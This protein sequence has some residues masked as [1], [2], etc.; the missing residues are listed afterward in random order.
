METQGSWLAR[1]QEHLGT[2]GLMVLLV[3]TSMLMPLSLDMYTPAVPHMAERLFTT[4]AMVNLT[5]VGYNFF[6]AVG[7]LI[8][9]P[10]SDRR[11]RRPVLLSGL[12]FYVA[13]SLACALAPSIEALIVARIV[14]SLGAG[15]ADA[16]TNAIVKDAFTEQRRQLAISF[17][18][19]MFIL[20][21]VVAPLVGAWVVMALD[22]R[23]TFWILTASGVFLSALACAF[24]ESLPVSERYVSSEKGE[25]VRQFAAVLKV[26]AFT[27][28]LLV[29]TLPNLGFMAYV[30]VASFVYESYFG[31]SE[32]GYG[33]YYAIAALVTV[34]G[35]FAWELASRH[36]QARTF[37]TAEIGVAVAAGAALLVFGHLA[38]WLFC[39]AFAVFAIVEASLRP[40]STNILLSKFRDAGGTTASAINF[41][42]MV[43]G[44]LGM[45]L[46][47]ALGTD[48][49]SS[50]AWTILVSMI[51]AALG[52]RAVLRRY[53]HTAEIRAWDE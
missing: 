25:T 43:K 2:L 30:S 32:L 47:G 18:Q 15:A 1:P 3:G 21:P 27:L 34:L 38:P 16:M 40:L 35:P 19:L 22:W 9:G 8:F 6:F 23:A 36:M 52:W 5:L 33:M 4:T 46:V 42:S 11:G 29:F 20:G 26:P 45:L 39:A 28:P 17:I 24:E 7:L 48:Y 44:S 49:V 31:L 41:T 14:Q 53:P 10:L 50:L 51:C 37:I 12:A 13:G